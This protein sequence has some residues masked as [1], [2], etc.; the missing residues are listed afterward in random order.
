MGKGS[1]QFQ[2]L[3]QVEVPPKLLEEWLEQWSKHYEIPGPL[4]VVLRPHTAGSELLQLSVSSVS[5][6]ELANVVFATI[7]DR[8]GRSI[9]SIRDQNTFDIGLRKKR[10]MTLMHLFLVHRYKTD[11]VHYV[12]PTQDNE[13]QTEKMKGLGLFDEVATEVGQIIVARVGTERIR[14]LLDPDRKALRRLITKS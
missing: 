8:R 3:A 7:Q 10:L 6:T 13:L 12:S 5:G 11:S 4:Q 1:T 14:S 9:L 2:H